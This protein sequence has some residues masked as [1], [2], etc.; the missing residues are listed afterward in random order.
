MPCGGQCSVDEWTA[1]GPSVIMCVACPCT[2]R[3]MCVPL[4][5]NVLR[6]MRVQTV[7]ENGFPA[8]T[9]CTS[10]SHCG[11]VR[12]FTRQLPFVRQISAFYTRRVTSKPSLEVLAKQLTLHW[13][14]H[15]KVRVKS[16]EDSSLS[17]VPHPVA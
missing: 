13:I 1:R 11:P 9:S 16:L 14:I 2:R 12:L 6:H 10:A 7:D 17:N 8:V 5:W 3:G 15:C 4:S